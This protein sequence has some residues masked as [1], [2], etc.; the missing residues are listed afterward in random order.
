MA[1][2]FSFD[3]VSKVDLQA[4]DNAVNSALREITTRFDFKGSVSRMELDKKAETLTLYSD[5][6]GKLKSV[7]DILQNRLVKHALSLKGLD[8]G[9]VLAAEGGTVRQVAKIVQGVASEKAKEMVRAIKNAKLK[10]TPSIQGDQLRVTGK[11]KDDLQSAMALLKGQDFGLALQF[12]N[13]R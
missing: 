6:E 1:Q 4:M 2:E 7:V 8:Y 5:N 3:V 13:F 10:V 12:V 9:P 11:S